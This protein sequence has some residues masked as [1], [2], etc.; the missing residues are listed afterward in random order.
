MSLRTNGPRSARGR[1][2][3]PYFVIGCDVVWR[4]DDNPAKPRVVVA[5]A[6]DPATIARVLNNEYE[7]W[8]LTSGTGDESGT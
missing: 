2:N 1:A 6:V 4:E 8:R 5:M 3:G 7:R